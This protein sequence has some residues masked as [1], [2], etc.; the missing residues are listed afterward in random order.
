MGSKNWEVGGRDTIHG[1]RAVLKEYPWIGPHRVVGLGGSYG[2]Y[3]SNWLNGNAPDG[4]FQALVCHC[5]TFDMRSSYYATDELFFKETECGGP[6]YTDQ[7]KSPDSPWSAFTPSA[8]VNDW[9]RL[10]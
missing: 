2:G 3:T 7:H 5:G 10:I 8:K 4:M 1:V 9:M 6:P